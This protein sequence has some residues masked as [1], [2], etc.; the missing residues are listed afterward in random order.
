M[1]SSVHISDSYPNK[2]LVLVLCS[3]VL[4]SCA[5][6]YTYKEPNIPLKSFVKIEA[7][8]HKSNCLTCI[9]E[10]GSGS[11]AVVGPNKIL[12]AGH[13]C[14]GIREMLDNAQ[15]SDIHDKVTVTVH[16]DRGNVYGATDLNIHVSQDICLIKTDNTVLVDTIAI[17]RSNPRR[18]K[19][20][21]GMMAPG[22]VS[23]PGLVPVVSGH[24]AGGDARTS[25][26]T[27]PA[28]PG[29]SGGPILNASGEIIGLVSQIN[30]NFHHIVIS[31]SLYSIREFVLMFSKRSE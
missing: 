10:I 19:M 17:A 22:G 1:I 9:Q 21:W 14:I 28:Y 29:A 18:G 24:Y 25:I 15:Q 31:P 20:V 3:T 26:F 6:T 4:Y 11:G 16:D 2:V 27:I 23:G 7:K 12:T 13:I 30:K 5:H 8:R